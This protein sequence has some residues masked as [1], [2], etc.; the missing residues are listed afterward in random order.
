MLADTITVMESDTLLLGPYS[1]T[2]GG[3]WSW[4]GAGFSSMAIHPNPATNELFI[5]IN[6]GTATRKTIKC[7]IINS[8]GQPLQTRALPA[9][10][11]Q[12]KLDIRN[13]EPGAY[14]L[15]VVGEK[16]VFTGRFVKMY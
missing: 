4:D 13:L 14:Y 5:K 1:S 11:S 3:T 6:N 8:V 15:K 12:I 16:D 7:S 9:Y 10:D 2:G